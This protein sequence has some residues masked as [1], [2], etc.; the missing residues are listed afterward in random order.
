MTLKKE[1]D[2]AKRM[3]NSGYVYFILQGFDHWEFR[4]DREA[5]KN[6]AWDGKS[7]VKIGYSNDVRN[8]LEALQCGN[9][10]KLKL[11]GYVEGG[12]GLER[13]IHSWLRPYRHCRGNCENACNCEWFEYSYRVA[14]YINALHLFKLDGGCSPSCGMEFDEMLMGCEC[15]WKIEDHLSS[16]NPEPIKQLNLETLVWEHK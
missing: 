4:S 13:D 6:R 11:L 10:M 15:V 8:R 16:L 1:T 3:R 2:R 7:Y 5:Y 12:T 9:P 14:Q